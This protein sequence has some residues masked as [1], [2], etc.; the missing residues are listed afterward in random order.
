MNCQAECEVQKDVGIA[1][2]HYEEYEAESE[3]KKVNYSV[4]DL[5]CVKFFKVFT[6]ALPFISVMSFATGLFVN[7]IGYVVGFYSLMIYPLF[8]LVTKALTDRPRTKE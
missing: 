3:D 7:K 5:K 8:H 2:I 6:N 4:S 1:C